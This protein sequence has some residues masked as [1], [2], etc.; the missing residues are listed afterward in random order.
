MR[1]I[2][3]I[4]I[5]SLLLLTS[6]FKGKKVDL[7][8]HNARIHTLDENNK[9]EDAIAIKDGKII[10]IGP[11]RQILNK[12][13]AEEELDALGKDITPGFYDLG[14]D[15]IEAVNSKMALDLNFTSSDDELFTR[16]EKF[17]QLHSKNSTIVCKN[18]DLNSN[19]FEIDL[20]KFNQT[21]NSQKIIIYLKNSDSVLVN[22]K[23]INK[24]KINSTQNQIIDSK[25]IKPILP[26]YSTK[27]TTQNILNFERAFLQYG[28]IGIQNIN[29]DQKTIELFNSLKSKN[30]LTI[31]IYFLL[32][33]DGLNR[34]YFAKSSNKQI[35]GFN[36]V[37]FDKSTSNELLNFYSLN[38]FQCF[39]Y[40]KKG[41]QFKELNEL[42]NEIKQLNPD[43]RWSYFSDSLNKQTIE[44][45]DDNSLFYN[46]LLNK[47][48]FS[49]SNYETIPSTLY[50]TTLQSNFPSNDFYPYQFLASG[51]LHEISIE[52]LLKN[53]TKN[54]AL[55]LNL[56][57]KT[58]TLEKG[59]NATFVIFNQPLSGISDNKP[60]YAFRTYINGKMVYSA[61]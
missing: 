34:K 52:N 8:I 28:I 9:I 22:K 49:K 40:D 10:E 23:V 19:S 60:L 35:K 15:L 46:V 3:Y 45:I 43:H 18:L 1:S 41:N 55:Y 39:I 54:A 42:L 7:I 27:E 29:S 17:S 14:V 51:Y 11:E 24:L 12:Y 4:S 26:H 25:L 33:W 47:D 20:I 30:Q 6:C 2:F 32:K 31:D 13:T 56:E 58:G 37:N 53:Y 48:L 59:K 5:S 36:L 21:F 50:L 16:I 57:S 44:L 38:Q 61:E